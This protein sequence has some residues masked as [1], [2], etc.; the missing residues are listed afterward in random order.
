MLWGDGEGHPWGVTSLGCCEG[1]PWDVM[2]DLLGML[3]EG[4]P[5]DVM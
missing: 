3:C 2:R 5:W 4:H 1:H